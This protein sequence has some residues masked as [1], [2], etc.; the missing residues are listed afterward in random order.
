V[1]AAGG[2]R[3]AFDRRHEH[4]YGYADPR[5][6]IEIVT[7]RVVAAGRTPKPALPRAR[8]AGD[9][10]AA[11][12]SRV[13]EAR[14]DGRLVATGYY[15]WDDL[16]SGTAADG[17]AI[18]AGGEATAVVPPGFAF[19]VDE[20]RNLVAARV[21]VASRRRRATVSRSA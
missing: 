6:P 10:S 5:R 21:P 20:L 1:P 8:P 18:V 19:H 11:A 4:A 17:P 12:P 7:L 15:R 9:R 2:F 3:E 14:F 13:R 16:P